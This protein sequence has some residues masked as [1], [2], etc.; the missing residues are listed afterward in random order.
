[1]V[2][3]SEYGF[4]QIFQATDQF[5]CQKSGATI[6]FNTEING[7]SALQALDK[8]AIQ[9]AFTD[10]PQSPDQQA[11]IKKDKLLLIPI[12]YS[13]N[14]MG[15]QSQMN[16]ASG[17]VSQ[18]G[19]KLTASLAAGIVGG[20]NYGALAD[21]Q[22]VCTQGS[23]KSPCGVM[24]TL[25]YVPGF[26]GAK[27]YFSFLRSDTAGTTD[28]LLQWVCDSGK[29]TN[30]PVLTNAT[31]T[32]TQLAEQVLLAGLFPAGGAPATG[33]LLT[34]QLPAFIS[35]AGTA[36]AF[37]TPGQQVL[38]LRQTILPA[39]ITYNPQW[40]AFAPMNWADSSYYGLDP[41]LLQNAA[42]QFVAPTAA[43]VDAGI[44]DG[45]WSNGL[46]TQNY[47]N[48]SD[49]GA[50]AM[51]TVM[52]AV[53]PT[54]ADI[55]ATDKSG[56]QSSLNSILDVTG[57]TSLSGSLPSGILPLSSE[58]AVTSRDEVA[59]GVGNPNYVVPAIGHSSPSSPNG[60]SSSSFSAS[61]SFALGSLSASALAASAKT[62]GSVSDV[63]PSSSPTYGPI[64]LT[65][66]EGRLLL[67]ATISLGALMALIGIAMMGSSGLAQRRARRVA[68]LEADAE[69]A[70]G[71][72]DL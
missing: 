14:V 13:G 66:T 35:I 34:D 9:M 5:T 19:I 42:D 48:T 15:G 25:N 64:T 4:Q 60:G 65:A 20:T 24:G 54:A 72:E 63:I 62:P 41:A 46:W 29:A 40:A 51:P 23:T 59:N 38:K 50:Y 56:I 27:S 67:P 49:A 57:A 71:G 68:T 36:Q 43:S 21:G 6:P 53:V 10:D 69:V 44:S 22:A 12:A 2:S 31:L 30:V 16:G 55:S 3:D 39:N 28:Q 61:S 32:E 11:I 52:Y 7:L 1:V 26:K 70:P 18:T 37:S 33:C 8:G 17:I 47:S 45:T 58:V